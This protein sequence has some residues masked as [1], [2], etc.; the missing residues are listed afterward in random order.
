MKTDVITVSNKGTEIEEAL[1]LT[2][3]FA[4]TKGLDTK[5]ALHLRLLTEEMMGMMRSITGET[6]GEFWIEDDTESAELHLRVKTLLDPQK[7][8]QLIAASTSGKNEATRTLMGKLRSFFEYGSAF[9]APFVL[10]GNAEMY[11]AIT[12]WSLKE[13]RSQLREYRAANGAGAEEEWD[14]L[15]KSVVS[16]V[17][18]EVKVSVENNVAEMIIY[19][20]ML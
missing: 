2:E 19:K 7:R 20:W 16:H 11:A 5:K 9:T 18:D 8:D 17:A 13:Y 14:E 6:Q 12:A 15:E 3:K 10:D 4:Q 1:K